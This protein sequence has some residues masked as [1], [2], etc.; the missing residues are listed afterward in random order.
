MA[1][2]GTQEIGR[3]GV[4]RSSRLLWRLFGESLRLP[5]NA[6]DHTS[7]LTFRNL[8]EFG[9]GT[10]TF[11][12]GG[13]L[14]RPNLERFDGRETTD[15]FV[16]VKSYEYG[17]NLLTEYAEF[18]RRA[19]ILS[20]DERFRDTCFIFLA[21]VPFGTSKGAELCDGRFLNE[22]GKEWPAR[23]REKARDLHTRICLIF[24]TAS[25][26]RM[27]SKWSTHA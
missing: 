6:Y 16:E 22:C 17:S 26:E 18:L 10:F 15:V 3:Q 11:D 27:L 20:L 9:G 25:F 4:I 14:E 13:H 21:S 5:F 23:V 7:K 19:A 1:A 8:E 12:L 2:E 24:A